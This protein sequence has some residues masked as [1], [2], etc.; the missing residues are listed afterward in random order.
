MGILKKLK[1]NVDP[2]NS[3][4]G[5]DRIRADVKREMKGASR[6]AQAREVAKR[7]GW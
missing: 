4:S 6:E 5:L 2:R 7:A 1:D 3:V